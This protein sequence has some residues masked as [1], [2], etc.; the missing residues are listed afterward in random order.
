MSFGEKE[1][2]KRKV[3]VAK[4]PLKIVMLVLNI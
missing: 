3:Y 1:I 4:I 2:R